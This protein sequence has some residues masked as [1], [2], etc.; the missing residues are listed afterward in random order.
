[1]K[2]LIILIL[3]AGLLGGAYISKPQDPPRNFVHHLVHEGR[4]EAEAKLTAATCEFVG[5]V[6]WVDVKQ[7]GNI[8][9]TGVF[10]RW[11]NRGEVR[12]AIMED[13]RKTEH[14]AR[15]LVK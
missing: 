1:M 12:H 3:L 13:V 14:A 9:Y 4:P 10:H 11:I 8:V 15:Q 2:K 6:F 7:D 5:R